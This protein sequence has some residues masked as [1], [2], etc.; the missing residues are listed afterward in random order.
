VTASPSIAGNLYLTSGL[1]ISS[2][3]AAASPLLPSSILSP[4]GSYVNKKTFSTGAVSAAIVAADGFFG[5]ETFRNTQNLGCA[6]L[7][8]MWRWGRCRPVTLS[9]SYNGEFGSEYWSQEGML[10]LSVEF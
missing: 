10:R 4:I 7:E 5:V 1:A 9:L 6:G 8:L 3:I 2:G